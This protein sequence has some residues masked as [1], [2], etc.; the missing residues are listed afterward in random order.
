[1]NQH[2]NL[3]VAHGDAA[4]TDH[5]RQSLRILQDRSDDEDFKRLVDD[6]LSGRTSLRDVHDSQAFSAVLDKGVREFR[7]RWDSL[8]DEERADLAEQGREALDVP[9]A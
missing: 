4:L 2:E 7:Q 1:M 8:T 9:R 3:D 5:L 6:V